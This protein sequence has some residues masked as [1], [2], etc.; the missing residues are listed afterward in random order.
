MTPFQHMNDIY[1][2]KHLIIP[3]ILINSYLL[4]FKLHEQQIKSISVSQA[5]HSQYL[6]IYIV[7]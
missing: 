2:V 7:K 4:H 6:S 1:N 5:K 3:N